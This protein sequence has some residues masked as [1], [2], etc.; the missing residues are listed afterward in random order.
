MYKKV[1]FMFVKILHF[2]FFTIY[3]FLFCG[4]NKILEKQPTHSISVDASHID[5]S[6][7][8]GSELSLKL[9]V[10]FIRKKTFGKKLDDGYRKIL[11]NILQKDNYKVL[12]H[13]TYRIE[14]GSVFKDM[15]FLHRD[16]RIIIFLISDKEKI[17]YSKKIH[18]RPNFEKSIQLKFI[19]SEFYIKVI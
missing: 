12:N 8:D 13:N 5:Q 6:M 4:C 16:V 18:I 17:L 19:G 2:L 9:E 10:L 14:K 15:Y 7:F 1:V 11:K 3:L